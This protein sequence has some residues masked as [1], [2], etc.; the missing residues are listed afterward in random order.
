MVNSWRG[1][2]KGPS[3]RNISMTQSKSHSTFHSRC[4]TKVCRINE[5]TNIWEM[6]YL[7]SCNGIALFTHSYLCVLVLECPLIHTFYI[8][9]HIEGSLGLSLQ[10]CE[11]VSVA[12]TP[13]CPGRRK[14]SR[15]SQLGKSF[16]APP[17]ITGGISLFKTNRELESAIQVV[18]ISRSSYQ[19]TDLVFKHI[20][21]QTL[22]VHS[23]L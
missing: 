22:K 20:K 3:F 18:A 7:S 16:A 11:S 13:A 19:N 4:S 5:E 10:T 12:C 9:I 23:D 14:T 21:Q 2:N 1:W 8:N 17:I 6:V 15:H